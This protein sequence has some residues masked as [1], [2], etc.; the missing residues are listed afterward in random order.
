MICIRGNKCGLRVDIGDY[1]ESAWYFLGLFVDVLIEI[2]SVIML[3]KEMVSPFNLMSESMVLEFLNHIHRG[4]T[5]LERGMLKVA[6]VFLNANI[7]VNYFSPQDEV[8][9][10]FVRRA[11]QSTHV[12]K[13]KVVSNSNFP[14]PFSAC[15]VLR[16]SLSFCVHCE[17]PH[18]S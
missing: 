9:P 16:V 2:G 8:C 1:D 6:L 14:C 15:L 4:L 5:P 17:E 7:Q 18:Q 13:S 12:L 11:T 3:K 10:F